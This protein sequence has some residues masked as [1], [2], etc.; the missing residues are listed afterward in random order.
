[1]SETT[2]ADART[3]V[4]RLES[5]EV[6][7]LA[8]EVRR[9]RAE[10][11]LGQVRVRLV[12]LIEI[13]GPRPGSPLGGLTEVIRVDQPDFEMVREGLRSHGDLQIV[14]PQDHV[15]DIS[16]LAALVSGLAEQPRQID[17]APLPAA[18][19]ERL[20]E[21]GARGLIASGLEDADLELHRQAHAI[22]FESDLCLPFGTAVPSK[23]IARRLDA[24][25]ALQAETGRLRAVAPY[26]IGPADV[27]RDGATTGVE[28][29]KIIAVTRLAMPPRTRVRADWPALTPRGAQLALT[30]GADEIIGL[31]GP[32][33]EPGTED[34][35]AALTQGRLKRLVADTGLSIET[36]ATAESE[37]R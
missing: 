3:I 11:G 12:E 14:W 8:A 24:L 32:E 10:H 35:P 4:R 6:F 18:D 2:E 20:Y 5:E 33:S 19:L 30:F 28:D 25:A 37:T 34:R 23:S 22:G 7:A 17:I 9:Y 1:M 13:G 36:L 15:P 29:L 31:A 27:P 16:A 26:P 21:A